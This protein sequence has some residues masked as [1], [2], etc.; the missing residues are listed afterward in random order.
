MIVFYFILALLS[1]VCFVAAAFGVRSPRVELVALGLAFWV[2]IT[3][4]QLLQRL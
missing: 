2:G 3:F 4:T 1:L